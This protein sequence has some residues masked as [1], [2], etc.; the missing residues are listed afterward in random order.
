MKVGLVVL[1]A[2]SRVSL[3]NNAADFNTAEVA[4]HVSCLKWGSV[5]RHPRKNVNKFGEGMGAE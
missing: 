2:G 3:A 1:R 5:D 4:A